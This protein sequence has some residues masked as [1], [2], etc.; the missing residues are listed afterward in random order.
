[1]VAETAKRLKN[2]GANGLRSELARRRSAVMRRKKRVAAP[3]RIGLAIDRFSKKRPAATKSARRQAKLHGNR[4]LSARLRGKRLS[5]RTKPNGR[6]GGRFRPAVAA[7]VCVPAQPTLL[8]SA[9]RPLLKLPLQEI[10]AVVLGEANPALQ[11]V[12]GAMPKVRAIY[13]PDEKDE[14]RAR[15]AGA[16]AAEADVVLFADGWHPASPRRLDAFLKACS[17]GCDVAL[18]RITPQLGIFAR[19]SRE[20]RLAA[21]L[22][23][24]LNRRDLGADSL[25]TLPFALS[26]RALRALGPEMLENPLKAQAAALRQGLRVRAAASVPVSATAPP[27]EQAGPQNGQAAQA[28]QGDTEKLADAWREALRGAP[29]R[30]SFPDRIRTRSVLAEGMNA[31]VQGGIS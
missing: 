5:T 24:A 9:L 30:L 20:F 14:W 7:V 28:R 17:R 23:R 21:F 29:A 22:N 10:I 4:R 15:A 27:G 19:W 2:S 26:R 31:T 13:L 1:M 6:G 3:K 16:A 18:N 8:Q 25:Q 12:I 11:A